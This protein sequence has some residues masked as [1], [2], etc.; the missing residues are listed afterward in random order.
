M[1]NGHRNGVDGMPFR[2]TTK[3]RGAGDAYRMRA[4]PGHPR[5][6]YTKGDNPMLIALSRAGTARIAASALTV[7]LLLVSAA[8]RAYDGPVEKKVFTLPSYTTVGGKT[9]KNVRVGY[10]TYGKLNAAGDNA[11]FV[12]HFFT[13][14][15]HA[16]GKY[17]PTDAAPGYWDPIIGAGRPIDTDKYFVISADALR[18][19]QHEGPERDDDRAVDDQ[20][21]DGQ[22]MGHGVPGRHLSR[23]RARAQGAWSTASA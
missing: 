10:E 22:A 2:G 8:A 23:H 14:T 4:S 12:P 19:S 9:L 20:P 17:A 18:Q 21:R 7:A 1:G 16:A 5:P 11:I 3:C 15:S 6:I 13:A